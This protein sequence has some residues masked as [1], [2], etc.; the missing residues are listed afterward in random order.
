MLHT[1]V[2]FQMFYKGRFINID[3]VL[4]QLIFTCSKSII[5]ALEKGVKYVQIE[6]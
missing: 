4:S 5:E 3:M 6:Q 1:Q 2:S